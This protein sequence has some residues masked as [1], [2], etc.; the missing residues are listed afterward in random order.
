AKQLQKLGYQPDTAEDGEQAFDK[1]RRDHYH[2][3]L[4]DC[5]MPNVSGYELARLIRSFEAEHPARPRAVIIACTAGATPEELQKTRDA[6]MD[7]YLVKPL[8]LDTLADMLEKWLYGEAAASAQRAAAPDA[9]DDKG[10]LDLFA[11]RQLG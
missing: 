6:G 10:P 4:T 11:L 8:A 5:L 3:V 2:L 9:F 7:G 1:W